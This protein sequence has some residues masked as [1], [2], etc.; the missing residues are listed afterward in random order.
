MADTKDVADTSNEAILERFWQF[1]E[2]V[3]RS[4]QKMLDM[5]IEQDIRFTDEIKQLQTK[6]EGTIKYLTDY[7]KSHTYPSKKSPSP[8]PL[9]E[10]YKNGK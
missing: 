9:K 1:C 4:E 8:L 3:R 7:Q 5:I 2:E 6:F 10:I